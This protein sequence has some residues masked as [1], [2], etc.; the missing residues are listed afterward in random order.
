M[1]V[2]KGEA[3]PRWEKLSVQVGDS[4]PSSLARDSVSE[5]VVSGEKRTVGHDAA[6]RV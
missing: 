6:P 4:H 2:W 1:G 3:K 5:R